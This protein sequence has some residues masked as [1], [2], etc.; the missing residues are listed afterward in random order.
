LPPDAKINYQTS[1]EEEE[2]RRKKK[3]TPKGLYMV[4]LMHPLNHIYL[5]GTKKK[6]KSF[7][8]RKGLKMFQSGHADHLTNNEAR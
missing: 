7:F 8:V 4:V 6:V 2:R 3:N 5:G 1:I